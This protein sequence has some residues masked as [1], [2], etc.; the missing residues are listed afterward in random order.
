[1][2]ILIIDDEEEVRNSLKEV[3]SLAGYKVATASNGKEALDYVRSTK[4]RMM[5][6]DISMPVM[7]GEE[8]IVALDSEK[9]MPPAILITAMAPWKALKLMEYG[10]GYLRKPINSKLLLNTI[11]T[12]IG[13]ENNN[14]RT[15]TC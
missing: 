8:L 1:M 7:D 5:L 3:L 14:E 6:V 2:P 4:V 9:N 13:K 10:V 11:E 12:L 15:V